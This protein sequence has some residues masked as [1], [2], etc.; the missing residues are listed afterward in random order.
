[1]VM[2]GDQNVGQSQNRKFDDISF[3][4]MVEFNLGTTLTNQNSIHEEIKSRLMSGN[5][6][7]HLV[8]KFLTFSLLSKNMKI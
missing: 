2:S 6:C 8:Q 4:R 5:T 1:M 7:Y 3:E